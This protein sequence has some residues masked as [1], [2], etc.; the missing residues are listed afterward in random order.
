[1]VK[2]EC[3]YCKKILKQ[4]I[5]HTVHIASCEKK[6]NEIINR[7][8]KYSTEE[9]MM[10]YNNTLAKIRRKNNDYKCDI[11]GKIY[12]S[13]N[14]LKKHT[15]KNNCSTYLSICDRLRYK[16]NLINQQST[17]ANTIP[18]NNQIIT[19][20]YKKKTIP[21]SLKRVVWEVCLR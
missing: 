19:E 16:Y 4:K 8:K 2:Y 5:H 1:M 17:N 18:T 15:L 6:F 10:E 9:M 20:K 11:C 14:G 12:T 21:L 13:Y 7:Y 3:L